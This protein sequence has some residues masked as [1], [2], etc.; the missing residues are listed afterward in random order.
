M[1]LLV[2]I[3]T[4]FMLTMLINESCYSLEHTYF[5][6]ASETL[7]RMT[8]VHCV[9]FFLTA[10][11]FAI[12]LFSVKEDPQVEQESF[13]SGLLT[14][15]SNELSWHAIF[16]FGFLFF[17]LFYS[18]PQFEYLVNTFPFVF[19]LSKLFEMYFMIGA[20]WACASYNLLF[21]S[22]I[23]KNSTPLWVSLGVYFAS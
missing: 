8:I 3:P 22:V 1:T 5:T 10:I 17:I 23:T 19:E 12:C 2:G 18:L 9:H 20:A 15:C 16:G 7:A 13:W 14:V 4:G 6:N 21:G 11:S